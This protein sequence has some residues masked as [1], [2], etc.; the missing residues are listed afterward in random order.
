MITS[1]VD[2]DPTVIPPGQFAVNN[3]IPA[4]YLLPVPKHTRGLKVRHAREPPVLGRTRL[5]RFG[6]R[7]F[8]CRFSRAPR[9]LDSP[10]S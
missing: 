10:L 7:Q 5:H 3:A 6:V 2:F 1:S 8:L 9:S 4:V